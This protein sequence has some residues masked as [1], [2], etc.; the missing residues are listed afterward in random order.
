MKYLGIAV[1][2]IVFVVVYILA[3]SFALVREPDVGIRELDKIR[4]I[5]NRRF[6]T[7]LPGYIK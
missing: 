7:E 4:T 1:F 5:E 2:G 6:G 3:F